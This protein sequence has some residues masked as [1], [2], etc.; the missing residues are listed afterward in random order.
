MKLHVRLNALAGEFRE[1]DPHA[2]NGLLAGIAV[3]D[4]LADHAV[5]IG[6][7][8]VARKDMGVD[9]DAGAARKV[10]G[11]DL[12][13]A[14][15]EGEGI[16]GIDAAFDRVTA[17]F[18][19]ALL[20]AQALARSNADLLADDVDA[21]D[22]F[23]HGVLDLHARIHLNKVELAVFVEELERART[24]V[25]DAAAGFNAAAAEL[26]DRAA[27]NAAGRSLLEHLLVAALHRAV[28]LA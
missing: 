10:P 4:E 28:A 18:E 20:E 1:R 12:S 16:L 6:R 26:F 3:G 19:V 8:R 14:G 11:R 25:A 27:G 5:V 15:R 23:R 7:N 22:E 2:G 24:A 21:R 17:E 9:A 13:R